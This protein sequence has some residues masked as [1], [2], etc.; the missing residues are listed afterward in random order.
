MNET[1]T[2]VTRENIAYT[3]EYLARLVRDDNSDG[4]RHVAAMAE[5]AARRIDTLTAAVARE[6]YYECPLCGSDFH[7]QL[8]RGGQECREWQ[9]AN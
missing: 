5:I 2:Q 4:L 9:N 7:T 3:L 1:A 8:E 6:E